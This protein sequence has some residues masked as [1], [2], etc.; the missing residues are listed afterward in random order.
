MIPGCSLCGLT[1]NREIR[2]ARKNEVDRTKGTRQSYLR[3]TRRQDHHRLRHPEQEDYS[4]PC[5]HPDSRCDR[6]AHLFF[7]QSRSLTVLCNSRR[8]RLRDLPCSTT[9]TYTN[10]DRRETSFSSRWSPYLFDQLFR[11]TRCRYQR[12][13]T[14]DDTRASACRSNDLLPTHGVS[15]LKL[16]QEIDLTR[17]RSIGRCSGSIVCD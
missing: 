5:S 2:S 11:N 4:P 1:S 17:R 13:R 6:L 14:E 12:S 15:R 16:W 10:N 9:W 8:I 7:D 3:R